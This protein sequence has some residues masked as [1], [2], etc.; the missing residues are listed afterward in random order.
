M[1]DARLDLFAGTNVR[2][3][4]AMVVA[5]ETIPARPLLAAPTAARALAT[6]IA[7]LTNGRVVVPPTGAALLR[8][9]RFLSVE[10]D[11]R[12]ERLDRVWITRELAAAGPIVAVNDLDRRR[13]A[14]DPVAIG[15]WTG[16]ARSDQ[17]LGARL[18]ADRDGL[19]AEIALAVHPAAI[20][21]TTTVGGL[22]IL[23]ATADQI[24]AEL[25]GRALLALASPDTGERIGPWEHPL[26][27]RATELHLGVLTPSLIDL[28]ADWCGPDEAASVAAFRNVVT[29]M[30]GMIGLPAVEIARPNGILMS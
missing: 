9:D 27:Q 15:I 26:V 1:P 2:A 5:N 20:L 3:M 12:G 19:T 11:G 4:I 8:R 14:R 21:L 16:F 25:A 6:S 18:S 24:A 30:T 7:G 23:V 22:P 17:R 29:E 10:L 13:S 28:A